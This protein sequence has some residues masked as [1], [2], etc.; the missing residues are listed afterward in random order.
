MK[1]SFES[2]ESL[3]YKFRQYASLSAK[4]R[5][6]ARRLYSLLP[7]RL[8][9]L[10]EEYKKK[11]RPGKA[12]RLALLSSQYRAY[13]LEYVEVLYQYDKARL[14]L[15]SLERQVQLEKSLNNKFIKK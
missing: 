5:Q 8:K 13:L 11:H 2:S 12:L 6:V 9:K 4:S 7:L 15:K 1:N 3:A 14:Y 10:E